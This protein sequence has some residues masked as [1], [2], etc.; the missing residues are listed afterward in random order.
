MNKL[1]VKSSSFDDLGY[2]PDLITKLKLF[3]R[4]ILII[5]LFIV[6]LSLSNFFNQYIKS[7]LIMICFLISIKSKANKIVNV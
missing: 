4:M 6:V 2:K 7:S 3:K 5:I 1:L